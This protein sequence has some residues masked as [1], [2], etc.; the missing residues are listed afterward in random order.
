MVF[1]AEAYEDNDE[2]VVKIAVLYFLQHDLI[3][4]YDR[5]VVTLLYSRL[6]LLFLV[7]SYGKFQREI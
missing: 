3:N 5:K 7:A 1:K 4:A 6:I 2:E